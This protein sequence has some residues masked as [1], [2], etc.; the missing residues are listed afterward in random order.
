MQGYLNHFFGSMNIVNSREVSTGEASRNAGEC[1]CFN[2]LFSLLAQVSVSK[3]KE[4][5]LN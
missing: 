2:D 1:C 4:I 5:I 3:E